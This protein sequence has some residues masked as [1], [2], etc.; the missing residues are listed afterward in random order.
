MK[1]YLIAIIGLLA[2]SLLVFC[3]PGPRPAALV[4]ADNL[5]LN[6]L[7]AKKAAKAAPRLYQVSQR[8][9]KLAEEAYEDGDED[10]CIHFSTMAAIQFST[11]MQHAKRLAAHNR[12]A[13]AEQQAD[14]ANK[15]KAQYDLRQAD[16][17][18]RIKRM[19]EIIALKTN[20][21]AEKKKSKKEKAR[22]AAEL[23]KAQAEAKTKLEAEQKAAAERLAA[24]QARA[25][26]MK[27]EKEVQEFIASASS[28]IQMAEALDAA[29]YDSAN[30]NS[31]KTFLEQAKKALTGKQ[32]KNATDLAKMS[33]KK[34]DLATAKAQAE[35]AKKKKETELLKEREELFKESN[36]IGGLVVKTEKRGV[37]MTLH[38]MF[39]PGKTIVLPERTYLLDK[40]AEL[41]RKYTDYPVVIEGYTDSRGRE[42]NNLAL[43]Q[44]RAQSVLDYLTQQQKMK[45]ERIKSSGYGEARP[46][47]DNSQAAGRAKN[48]RVE[49]IFLFR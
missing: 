45:F 33:V 10:E 31:A 37:V 29:K 36:A 30:I 49:V 43:S 40:I 14:Q 42:T 1:R 16:A 6:K 46:I 24:E 5:V 13:K 12:L 3:G 23:K 38:E 48:R 15:A 27:Q 21:A 22:I 17:E 18:K 19:E 7:D 35:Y 8:Y 26:E 28:K 41:A 20:L 44:G 47:A 25:E 39:A 11:A 32:F 34:A 9:Y 2:I 4:K